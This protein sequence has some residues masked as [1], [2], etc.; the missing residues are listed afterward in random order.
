MFFSWRQGS[1]KYITLFCCGVPF[2]LWPLGMYVFIKHSSITYKAY[3]S[4]YRT[5]HVKKQN[6]KSL[7]KNKNYNYS[8]ETQLN[9]KR[10]STYTTKNI[11]VH[12]IMTTVPKHN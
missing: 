10:Y 9:D 11:R 4:G 12:V 5:C 3:T 7:N 2:W 8:E 1:R 6:G